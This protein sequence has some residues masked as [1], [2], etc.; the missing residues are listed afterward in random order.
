MDLN[1]LLNDT[2]R[3][4]EDLAREKWKLT[5]TCNSPSLAPQACPDKPQAPAKEL[6]VAAE[7]LWIDGDASHLQQ[8]IENLLFNARDATFEMRNHLRDEARRN[9]NLSA[10]DR[11]KALI[12]AAGWRGRVDL[13]AWRDG[14]AT[15][16]K[17]SA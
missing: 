13:R 11:R 14:D 2:A 10:D 4:W 16:G 15:S 9:A 5:L 12:D 6:S 7:P 17:L 3:T 8:A 1:E